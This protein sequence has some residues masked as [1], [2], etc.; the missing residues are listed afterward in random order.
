M[1]TFRSSL[2]LASLLGLMVS[3]NACKGNNLSLFGSPSQTA[4]DAK[5]TPSPLASPSPSPSPSP[6]ATPN[7]PC[8]PPVTGINLSGQTS[9]FSG[10]EFSI[11][12]TPVSASGPLD[13]A[14]D[15][16]NLKRTPHVE[17][18]SANLRCAGAC[19][20]YRPTFL[21]QG[22]GPFEVRIRVDNVSE[23]FAGTVLARR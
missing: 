17:S 19:S 5:A 1:R 3:L 13:G 22:V 16:C 6:T 21:A 20:G 7:D 8:A 2:A 4:G 14:L 23:S 11:E 9:V 12:V 15:Y 10:S 18:M